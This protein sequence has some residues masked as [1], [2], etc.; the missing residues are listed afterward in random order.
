MKRQDT[1]ETLLDHAE[2][3]MSHKG[4][5]AT[6]LHEL[7][8]AAGVSRGSF[9]HF[10]G[11][12]DE[13]LVALLTRFY[14]R[15]QLALTSVA[16]K[17]ADADKKLLLYFS[18]WKQDETSV[19]HYRSSLIITL[20][21]EIPSLSE[22]AAGAYLTGMNAII[23]RLALIIRQGIQEGSI[24]SLIEPQLLARELVN[25]WTGAATLAKVS[26][27]AERMSST[28]HITRCLLYSTFY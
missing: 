10:F 7:L 21:A 17:E 14:T 15:Y 22:A 20:A 12:K 25:L 16:G 3:I 4:Y 2:K 23:S 11:S 8:D 5:L 19:F 27:T 9:Y 18:L 24:I 26:G 28:L 6:G 13:L 1:V